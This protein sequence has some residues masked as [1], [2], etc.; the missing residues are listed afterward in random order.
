ME[1]IMKKILSILIMT[2]FIV[3]LLTGCKGTVTGT[4]ETSSESSGTSES[5]E[6]EPAKDVVLRF[7]AAS[8]VHITGKANGV[9]A[10]RLEKAINYMY[11]YAGTQK[12]N[13]VD[14]LLLSG[15]NTDQGTVEQLNELKGI[16]ITIYTKRPRNY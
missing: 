3:T 13:K 2:T 1:I 5:S 16:L 6:P 9:Q 7:V 10:Q 14:L 12:Y 4:S 8:D 11:E 15:D